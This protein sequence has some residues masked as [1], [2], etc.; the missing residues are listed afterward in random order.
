MDG[1]G[2]GFATWKAAAQESSMLLGVS[3][4]FPK[5]DEAVRCTLRALGPGGLRVWMR[6]DSLCAGIDI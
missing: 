1:Y 6:L 4:N 3:E 5:S 2:Y